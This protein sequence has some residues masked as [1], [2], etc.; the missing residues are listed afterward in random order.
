[1]PR[2]LGPHLDIPNPP[3]KVPLNLGDDAKPLDL[4]M[5]EYNAVRNLI[6]TARSNQV[7][8]L[9]FGAATVG[10]LVSAAATLWKDAA[11]LAG[12]ILLFAVPAVCFLALIIYGG[13]AIRLMR[14]GLFLNDLENWVNE[15]AWPSKLEKEHTGVLT[16]EQWG[17]RAGSA[18]VE[19]ATQRAIPLIF[20]LLAFGFMIVGY[21]RLHSAPHIDE[22]W[23]TVGLIGASLVA[24]YL[25]ISAS[26]I[27]SIAYR[28]R[29]HYRLTAQN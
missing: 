11:A 20:T 9:S 15:A 8:I 12:L 21:V 29:T 24:A 14:A 25:L 13:E 23:A 7:A 5:H 1:M 10:L 6:Q 4:V 18:D 22:R 3:T 27:S 28:Y 17:V 16:W 26:Y 2:L 19:R